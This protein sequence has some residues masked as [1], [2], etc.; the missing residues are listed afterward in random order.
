MLLV[1]ICFNLCKCLDGCVFYKKSL[2]RTFGGRRI[3]FHKSSDLHRLV[4]T[5]KCLHMYI[6]RNNK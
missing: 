6:H 2:W 1:Q 4:T 5:S 3:H